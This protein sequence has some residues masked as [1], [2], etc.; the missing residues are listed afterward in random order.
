[1]THSICSIVINFCILT[2]ISVPPSPV[3]QSCLIKKGDNESQSQYLNC[4]GD[5]HFKT[6]KIDCCK[7]TPDA[8]PTC[9]HVIRL[10]NFSFI[11]LSILVP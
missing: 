3:P 6:G 2:M 7:K 1:M 8:T 10:V 11:Q 9:C 5:T 4:W